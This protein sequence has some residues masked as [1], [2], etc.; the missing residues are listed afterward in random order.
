VLE[1]PAPHLRLPLRDRIVLRR[2]L[3]PGAEF[4]F[5][6]GCLLVAAGA[7][8][9]QGLP[10]LRHPAQMPEGVNQVQGKPVF[11]RPLLPEPL[12]DRR[13]LVR[14]VAVRQSAG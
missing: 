12:Q 4:L 13:R 8:L 5:R 6:F 10:P 14:L 11:R 3:G 1:R 2:L 7:Q 9:P